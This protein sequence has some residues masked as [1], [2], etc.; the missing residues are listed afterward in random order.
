MCWAMM[1]EEQYGA[2]ASHAR[3]V[4]VNLCPC[5]A[6][7]AQLWCTEQQCTAYRIAC[8]NSMPRV[9]N[10]AG[11][12]TSRPSTKRATWIPTVSVPGFT[13]C[14]RSSTELCSSAGCYRCCPRFCRP[15]GIP[16]PDRQI[17]EPPSLSGDMTPSPEN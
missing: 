3:K 15:A 16:S 9:P 13:V 6:C 2:L 4:S 14:L 8:L 7:C 1:E 17:W 12:S 5:T 11:M 10:E